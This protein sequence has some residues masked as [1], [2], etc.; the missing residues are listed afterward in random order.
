MMGCGK[1]AEEIR[2]EKGGFNSGAKKAIK[3]GRRGK[4]RMAK[5]VV[6]NSLLLN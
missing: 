4:N 1:M 5:T 2:R 6:R 3:E